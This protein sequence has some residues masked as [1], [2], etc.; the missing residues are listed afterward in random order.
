MWP[1]PD[2]NRDNVRSHNLSQGCVYHTW[3]KS[4]EYSAFQERKFGKSCFLD[5]STPSPFQECLL[6]QGRCAENERNICKYN[7][8]SGSKERSRDGIFL[9]QNNNIKPSSFLVDLANIP[10]LIY[11]HWKFWG[12]YSIMYNYQK[13]LGLYWW[14][15]MQAIREMLPP[16]LLPYTVHAPCL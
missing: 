15:S 8:S 1:W 6:S 7:M 16:L 2:A 5:A 12:L 11:N 4:I 10:G 13:F 3:L 14:L 9:K